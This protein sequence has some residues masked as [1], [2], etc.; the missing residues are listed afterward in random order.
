MT[1]HALPN[2]RSSH[3]QL[4]LGDDISDIAASEMQ[5]PLAPEKVGVH[6]AKFDAIEGLCIHLGIKTNF[7]VLDDKKPE[8]ILAEGAKL[9]DK[10]V[11]KL[12]GQN[13]TGQT[14]Q[15][16]NAAYQYLSQEDKPQVSDLIFVFGGRTPLRIETAI[17]LF[18]DGLAPRILVSGRGPLYDGT[19][20]IPEARKYAE[21]AMANG[22]P[23]SAIL[24]EDES[25]T[26]VD[27]IKRSLSLLESSGTSVNSLIIVNSPYV[28]RRGWCMWRKYLPDSCRLYRVNC[29]TGPDLRPET[30]YRNQDGLRVVLGEFI[31]LRTGVAFDS[32]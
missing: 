9:L 8:E 13:P 26:L 19:I 15:L 28:Q 10:L 18:N 11:V 17:T 21:I 6:Y 31:K 29:A 20:E 22:V 24:I 3:I 23:Q 27:N 4:P 16:L 30:W 32:V 25:I 2:K 12:L 7:F 1:S 5:R 14:L